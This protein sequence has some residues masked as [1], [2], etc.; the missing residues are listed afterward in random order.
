MK[1]SLAALAGLLL[2]IGCTT[3]YSIQPAHLS[4]TNRPD[5]VWVTRTDESTL[6]VDQPRVNGDSLFGIVD[7]TPERISLADVRGLRAERVSLTRT[8]GLLVAMSGVTAAVVYYAVTRDVGQ[9]VCNLACPMDHPD[10]C[11]G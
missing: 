7:G 6:A 9:R 2:T 5:R 10:C 4:P 1:L 3:R 8:A 11:A